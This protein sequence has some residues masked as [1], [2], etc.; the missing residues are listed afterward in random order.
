MLTPSHVISLMSQDPEE[1]NRDSKIRV[2]GEREIQ[3]HTE[4]QSTKSRT[5]VTDQRSRM[6]LPS[7]LLLFLSLPPTLV[8]SPSCASSTYQTQSS[9]GP[10][11]GTQPP[12][13]SSWLCVC[14]CTR[15]LP[16]VCCSGLV[17]TLHTALP[18]H[19]PTVAH[20]F[21]GSDHAHLYTHATQSVP[22]V[23]TQKL[24][25]Q[26]LPNSHLENP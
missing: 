20:I 1:R 5:A 25:T 9:S 15:V 13:C 7:L 10:G 17:T 8:S 2:L 16:S 18:H 19:P 4:T 26:C 12:P 24:F 6:W 11:T 14:V 23:Q 22:L 21:S 3:S